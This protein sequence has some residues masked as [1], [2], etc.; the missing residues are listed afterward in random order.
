MIR[1]LAQE[2]EELGVGRHYAHV[3]RHGLDQDGGELVPF[4]GVAHG[5]AIVPRHDHGRG[6][7]RLGDARARR[8]ALSR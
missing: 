5:V 2:L 3:R 7:R 6:G 8:D 4:G 1:A